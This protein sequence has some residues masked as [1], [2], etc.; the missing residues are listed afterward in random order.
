MKTFK[1][2]FVTGLV[3]AGIC[4]TSY[5]TKATT[6]PAKVTTNIEVKAPIAKSALP[7]SFADIVEPLLPA[8][9]NI[10]TSSDVSKE[11]YTPEV[12]DIYDFFKRFEEEYGGNRG[13]PKKQTAL[14]SGFIIS[15]D[16]Y[17]VTN[18]HV[19]DDAD[20]ITV[21]LSDKTGTKLKAKIVG[22][23]KRTDLALL[24]INHNKPLQFV[25]F[26]DSSKVRVG[27]WAIAIGNP[28]GL[29]S[30]VTTGIISSKS[31][32]IAAMETGMAADRVPFYLQL[33]A[34]MNVG[35]SGGPTFDINGKVIGVNTAI[36]SPSGGSVGIGFAVPSSIVSDIIGKLRKDGKIVRGW[37]GI[38]IQA[39]DDEQLADSFHVNKG[40][41]AL[42]GTIFKNSP[43]AKSGLKVGDIILK[44]N[45][46]DVKDSRHLGL[47]VGGAEIGK[48][49]K[50]EILR[51]DKKYTLE[52][53][54]EAAKNT[55][56]TKDTAE[57]V[58]DSKKIDKILDMH[59]KE[60]SEDER[61][62]MGPDAKG[63]VVA[64][65]AGYSEAKEKGITKGDVIIQVDH[66]DVNSVKEV[67]ALIEKA[68][69]EKK[70]V[71]LLLVARGLDN[72]FV[73]LTLK[74]RTE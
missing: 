65:V 20:E 67:L 28:F 24:K 68:R 32:D 18:N 49:A 41:G 69:K 6:P 21:V 39:L 10:S 53:A 60:F 27:D 4:G 50:L 63:V 70:K 62:K 73:A 34:P 51:S 46:M 3:S 45:D 15:S 12:P 40:E 48:K 43:A 47:L 31:R 16:G 64:G 61:V 22:R 56:E 14:G 2:L 74:E 52:V 38:N 59:L 33:D 42:V 5:A 13:K 37:L 54:I 25:E 36:L 11:S 58:V 55:E 66:T 30:T 72:R 9:V 17:V 19:I 29:S 26:G 23:D 7:V 71:I 57:P 44:F 8:V 35:N 1:L